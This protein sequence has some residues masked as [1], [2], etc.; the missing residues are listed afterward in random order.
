MEK[1]N[2]TADVMTGPLQFAPGRRDALRSV[3][4]VKFDGK[5]QKAMPDIYTWNGKDGN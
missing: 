2:L 4:V 5:T 1:L 3:V